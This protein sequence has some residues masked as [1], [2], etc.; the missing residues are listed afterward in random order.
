MMDRTLQNIPAGIITVGLIMLLLPPLLS[1]DTGRTFTGS[2]LIG[3]ACAVLLLASSP[4]GVRRK[5]R[6]RMFIRSD[7]FRRIVSGISLLASLYGIACFPEF[8]STVRVLGVMASI[9][10]LARYALWRRR[11]KQRHARYASHL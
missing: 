5:D 9:A 1:A 11:T 2:W 8:D 4:Y 7:R 3:I 6:I 10:L